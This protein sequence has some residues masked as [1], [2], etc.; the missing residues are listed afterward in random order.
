MRKIPQFIVKKLLQFKEKCAI[1]L[2]YKNRDDESGFQR[3]ATLKFCLGTFRV[4]P[5]PQ[6]GDTMSDEIKNPTEKKPYRAVRTRTAGRG[7]A[8]R[9]R[10]I[11]QPTADELGYYLWDVEYVKEG[12]DFILRVTIDRFDETGE[13]ITI[14]DCEKMTRP[15][16]DILDEKDPISQNYILEVGSAGLERTLCQGWHFESCIG[17]TVQAHAIRPIDGERDWIGELAEFDGEKIKIA[18]DEE[19]TVELNI[20]ELAYVKLYA[21]IDF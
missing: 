6:K 21:G 13:G 5:P 17:E 10:E 19:K 8:D 1:L 9:V 4:S 3:K 11:I 15:V 12:A 18:M 20:A 2:L 16:S 7:I 14:D